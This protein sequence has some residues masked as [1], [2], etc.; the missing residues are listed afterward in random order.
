MPIKN[1]VPIKIFPNIATKI[2]LSSCEISEF[3]LAPKVTVRWSLL[4]SEDKWIKSDLIE[5]TPSEYE[6][7][8]SDDMYILDL[9]I[10]KLGLTSQ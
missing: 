4:N 5:I 6:L 2:Q 9:V 3:G 10:L 1:I 8:G 7:W